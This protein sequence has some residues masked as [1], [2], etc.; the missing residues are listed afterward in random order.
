MNVNSDS[1]GSPV[2]AGGGR[3]QVLGPQ[4]AKLRWPVDV[5]MQGT[6]PWEPQ[7]PPNVT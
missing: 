2:L 6:I 1:S 3:F 5:L 4:T 7:T